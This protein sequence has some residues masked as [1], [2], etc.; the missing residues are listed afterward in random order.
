MIGWLERLWARI[1][2]WDYGYC[3]KHMTQKTTIVY[4]GGCIS[5]CDTCVAEKKEQ[6]RVRLINAMMTLKKD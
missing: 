4:D 3:T 6:E 1:I 2:L 5:E